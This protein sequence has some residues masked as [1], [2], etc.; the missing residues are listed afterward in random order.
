MLYLHLYYNSV[1]CKISCQYIFLLQLCYK[2]KLFRQAISI[3]FK[4]YYE[5]NIY[6]CSDS[7]YNYLILFFTNVVLQDRNQSS[8]EFIHETP[9]LVSLP[10][11]QLTMYCRTVSQAF[12]RQM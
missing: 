4:Q 7:D 3:D 10:S 6:I 8:N 9:A 1:T 12:V 2:M 11:W 5:F